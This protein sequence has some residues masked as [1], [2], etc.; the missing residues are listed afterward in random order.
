MKL[1]QKRSGTGFFFQETIISSEMLLLLYVQHVCTNERSPH[2]WHVGTYKWKHPCS[3]CWI[4]ENEYYEHW[5]LLSYHKNWFWNFHNAAIS[6]Q[7]TL[8][9]L[10]YELWMIIAFK[11]FKCLLPLI[12]TCKFMLSLCLGTYIYA[13]ALSVVPSHL[14]SYNILHLSLSVVHLICCLTMHCIYH[15]L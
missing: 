3:V 7:R 8:P 11:Q 2:M 5:F 1:V 4:L 9:K 15:C 10:I 6:F 13:L 12:Y 14:L